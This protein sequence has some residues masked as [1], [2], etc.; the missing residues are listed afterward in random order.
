MGC[1]LLL[2]PDASAIFVIGAFDSFDV[3]RIRNYRINDFDQNNNGQ[4][5]ET[6]GIPVEI[7]V[8]KSGFTEEE[9]TLIRESFLTWEEVPQS[10]A[11]FYEAGTFQDPIIAGSE[12]TFDLQNSIV[13]Q[14]DTAGTDDSIEPDP[15]T[16]LQPVLPGVL[17]YNIAAWAG[18]DFIIDTPEGSY[19][20]SSGQIIDNDVLIYADMVRPQ[21]LGG[22]PT[23]DFKSV[24]VH[25]LGHFLGLA[26]TPLSNLTVTDGGIVESAVMTHSV[27][28]VKRR[29]GVTPTMFPAIFDLTTEGG[30]QGGGADLAPDDISAISWLYP[31]GSQDL[32]FGLNGEA[33]TRTRVGGG[34]PSIAVPLAH[35]VAWGDLDNDETTPRVAVFS[36][37]T[38]Y[39][40]N[41]ENVER[42]GQ[43]ELINLWRQMETDSGLFNATYTFTMTPMNGGGFDR[44]APPIDASSFDR[45]GNRGEVFTAYTSEVF[46][47]VEPIVDVSNKDAGTPFVWDYELGTLVSTDTGRTI[48]SIVGDEPMFGDPNDVCILNV[49]SSAAAGGGAATFNGAVRGANSVRSL[50][51]S[52]LMETALGSLI[53]DSYYKVSPTAAKFLLGNSLAYGATVKVVQMAYWCMENI[54][55]VLGA[56]TLV[57]GLGVALYK[58][59]RSVAA[60][61]AGAV[62][63]ACIAMSGAEALILYQTTEQLVAGST[64]IVSGTVVSANPRWSGGTAY[65]YTDIVI[66]I[67]DKAKGTLNKQSDLVITQIGGRVGGLVSE[68]S[69][70]PKFQAGEMVLLYLKKNDD[71]EFV[72]Y[73][74]LAGKQVVGFDAAKQTKYVAIPDDLKVKK[75][76]A[77]AP[78]E[79]VPETMPLSDF[80]AEL[81]AIAK[82]QEKAKS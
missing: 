5:E 19:Q 34:V 22:T 54:L 68:N 4:I 27:A 14:V 1:G 82:A 3:L 44:Q 11:S 10:Y 57:I 46:H 74:G 80:L 76:A 20:I 67:E 29:I 8:G 15:P 66:E 33:R 51:D 79:T 28:G 30:L 53:V 45:I 62:L 49:V 18:D 64:D 56:L 75:A 35:I 37:F 26:H 50:R 40:E 70:L 32:F 25:E 61:A 24:M 69:E 7:E 16:V 31:R 6:E 39:F 48:E 77:L 72:I 36:A 63:L 71:G 42:D 2:A 47:E 43:F 38:A 73:N 9:L 12:S 52:V 13:M 59:R 65:V 55:M 17:G 23:G 60:G 21:E 81:R 41:P 78:G 58:K